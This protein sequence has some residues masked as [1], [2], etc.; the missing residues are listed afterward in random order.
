MGTKALGTDCG[1]LLR[2]TFLSTDGRMK[3]FDMEGATATAVWFWRKD[4]VRYVQ[5]ANVGD[6]T[7][8]LCRDGK[9]ITL[10]FDHKV[11]EASERKR[12]LEAGLQLN[13]GATRINGIFIIFFNL[14][15]FISILI[16]ILLKK[17]GLAVSRALGD[18][19]VKDNFKGVTAEPY[20]SPVYELQDVTDSILIVASDGV[21]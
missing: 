15:S 20:I 18:H 12:L 1:E 13:E 8:F 5:T 6:S 11:N 4:G 10:S 14:F 7:A 16:S 17:K 2:E 19:F 21:I 9:A 3:E